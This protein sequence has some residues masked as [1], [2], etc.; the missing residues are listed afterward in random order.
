MFFACNNSETKGALKTTEFWVFIV[1]MIGIL[2]AVVAA[3]VADSND[4]GQG[5]GAPQVWSLVA[6][7][8]VGFLLGR[9][10]ARAC[11]HSASHNGNAGFSPELDGRPD[12]LRA[13]VRVA[14]DSGVRALA[15]AWSP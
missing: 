9:M 15:I 10:L 8:A 1:I 5:F 12:G 7:V 4:N 6:I 13:P 11:L 14:W 3:A 2:V